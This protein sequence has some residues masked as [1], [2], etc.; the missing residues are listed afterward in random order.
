MS[1]LAD[2]I[3]IARKAEG[4]SN[5]ERSLEPSEDLIW[6]VLHLHK[7]NMTMEKTRRK[8]YIQLKIAIS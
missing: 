2:R 6:L 4:P 8:M 3:K 5:L 1:A 7:T